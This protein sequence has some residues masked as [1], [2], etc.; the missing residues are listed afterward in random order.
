MPE[1]G[2]GGISGKLLTK[3]SRL[4]Q[5]IILDESKNLE[6]IGVGGIS[7]PEDVF[8]LWQIGGKAFQVYTAYVYQGPN[9]LKK[10]YQEINRFLL[11]Q[12]LSLAQFFE[13]SREERSYRISRRIQ[14]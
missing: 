4:I 13:L 2:P 5:Q 1:R 3:K 10:I 12:E 14:F 9:L 11:A 8:N 6:L 7:G